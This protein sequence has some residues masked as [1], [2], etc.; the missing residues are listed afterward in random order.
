MLERK[1]WGSKRERVRCV[2]GREPLDEAVFVDQKFL[3]VPT[4]IT[5]VAALIGGGAEA[6]KQF[7]P[8][9]TVDLNLRHQRKG[10]AVL[11]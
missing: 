2:T 10:H 1:T 9:V 5:G 4:D 7:E 11:G 3:E 8:L 6:V